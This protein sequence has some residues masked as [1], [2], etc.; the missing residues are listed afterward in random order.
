MSVFEDA[1]VQAL[2]T[3]RFMFFV[4]ATTL[5]LSFVV[6]RR[7]FKTVRIRYEY[8]LDEHL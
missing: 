7:Q 6:P 1:K 2:R 8:T 3:Y 5:P 4:K